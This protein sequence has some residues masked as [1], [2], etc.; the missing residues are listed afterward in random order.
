MWS[1]ATSQAW[2]RLVKADVF[3]WLLYR[4]CVD[5]A[6]DGDNYTIKHS[7]TIIQCIFSW[8]SS[9]T[10]EPNFKHLC[11]FIPELSKAFEDPAQ[12]VV[13]GCCTSEK[14]HS[15][16][17]RFP[18]LHILSFWKWEW[19]DLPRAAQRLCWENKDGI[20][21]TGYKTATKYFCEYW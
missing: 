19:L 18:K 14:H 13:E 15:R 9:T 16:P 4:K 3:L 2:E 1:L 6:F 21:G 12:C 8:S 5:K 20:E 11:N 10:S 17:L 7:N